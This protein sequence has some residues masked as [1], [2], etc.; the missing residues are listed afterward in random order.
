M[1]ANERGKKPPHTHARATFSTSVNAHVK[2][3]KSGQKNHKTCLENGNNVKE[4]VRFSCFFSSLSSI[5]AFEHFFLHHLRSFFLLQRFVGISSQHNHGVC[6]S[7]CRCV[8]VCIFFSLFFKTSILSDEFFIQ[9][10][11]R[12]KKSE[13]ENWLLKFRSVFGTCNWNNSGLVIL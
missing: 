9:Q 11:D 8:F 5:L 2:W 6:E 10:W 12:E 4:M 1:E 7:V 13:W 3:E